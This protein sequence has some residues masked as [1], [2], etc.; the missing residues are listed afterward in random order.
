MAENVDLNNIRIAYIGGGS[1]NWARCLMC[2]LALQSDLSGT[3]SLYDIDKDAARMNME[4][5]NILA[6]SADAKSRWN[7][8]AADC[9]RDALDGAEFVII[10]I[11]PG[12][13]S[14]MYA[15]VHTPER[16]GIYQSVG[17]TVGPAGLMR[18]LRAIPMYKE[19]AENIKAYA[20]HAWVINYT[21]PMTLCVRTLYEVFP[22]IKAFG[23]CHNVFESQNLLACAL[24]EIKGIGIT[25]RNEIKVNVLGINHFTW[26]DQASYKTIDVMDIFRE[27]ACRHASE[28]YE[29]NGA[30]AWEKDVGACANKVAF[31]LFNRY[32]VMPASSDRH[33]AEF[34]P[35]WY[36]KD[37]ETVRLW[38]FGLTP[39]K[40]RI[41]AN[42]AMAQ[43]R[44]DILA[45][46]EKFIPER[47]DE[48]GIL[49]MKALLGLGDFVTNMNIPNYGQMPGIPEGSI[50]ET[51]ALI[52]RDS[53]RPVFAGRLPADLQALTIR[54]AANQEM[55]L[56]AALEKDKNL[57]FRAFINDP[58]MVIGLDEARELFEEM[59]CNT[60]EYLPGWE[61]PL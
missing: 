46:K 36:L 52:T 6:R 4:M 48:E 61:I 21:N 30:G 40:L 37:L 16:F 19:F 26:I 60:R 41:E 23:C 35:P 43:N 5:G 24:K 3:V 20:P 31:D 44:K 49:Q 54:H 38:K 13:F 12:T 11:L 55:I 18:A 29:K 28:G 1:K 59:L 57:A 10:S 56:K 47:S 8:N 51:N 42:K 58:L 9:L 7:Y 25:H 45:G 17:D 14:E 22:E 27:F 15:D 50:V 33:I 34:F 39:V 53:I 32:G 2:D